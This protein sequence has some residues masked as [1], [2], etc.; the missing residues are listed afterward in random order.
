VLLFVGSI[1]QENFMI[2]TTFF[3]SASLA[4]STIAAI[5]I[6]CFGL[7][8][9]VQADSHENDL[10]RVEYRQTVMSIIGGNMGAMGDIMKNRLVLP[11]HVAVHAGQIAVMT[12]LIAPA[13]KKNI[14][15]D[16]TDAK[17]EIW[18]DWAK[19]E[20][21]IVDLEEAAR[22]LAAVSRGSD[23]AAVKP[24]MK[25]LGKGCGGCH[26]SFRRPKEES[27]RRK[28]QEH[29]HDEHE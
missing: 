27:F 20:A 29:E 4:R 5:L 16:A 18:Q 13:F 3:T 6:V 15:T 7:A 24:A 9:G 21:A 12:Q 14:A 1:I 22:N 26:E 8:S 11:G 19:F 25:A 17:P 2:R 10:P 23:P 28:P